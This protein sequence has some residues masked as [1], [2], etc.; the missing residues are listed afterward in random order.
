MNNYNKYTLTE[1]H[2]RM[3]G[4]MGLPMVEQQKVKTGKGLI[5][6]RPKKRR[7]G[8]YTL[9]VSKE[10][11][12]FK[13]QPGDRVYDTIVAE[14]GGLDG[15]QIVMSGAASGPLGRDR[16]TFQLADAEVEEGQHSRIKQEIDQENKKPDESEVASD[17][18]TE[19]FCSSPKLGR[20]WEYKVENEEWFARKKGTEKWFNLS[21][22]KF[23]KSRVSLD[24]YCPDFRKK[25]ETMP[26]EEVKV[27]EQGAQNVFASA[28]EFIEKTPRGQHTPK[29]TFTDD[30]EDQ[31]WIKAK[32]AYGDRELAIENGVD[33]DKIDADYVANPGKGGKVIAKTFPYKKFS[34]I[35]EGSLEIPDGTTLKSIQAA[36]KT[37][38]EVEDDRVIS[39]IFDYAVENNIEDQLE[40]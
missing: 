39:A 34:F 36:W 14:V 16:Y 15:K 5:K 25:K 37:A 11:K 4:L 2:N 38:N 1:E 6:V 23:L 13:L 12:D 26:K 31:Y 33:V 27:D 17:E 19:E 9:I 10:F 30:S 35:D 22:D 7:E 24:K 3:R 32:W 28:E 20:D 8:A 29:V 18:Q 21:A 40:V